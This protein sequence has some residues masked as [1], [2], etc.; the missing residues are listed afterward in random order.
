MS[1]DQAAGAGGR[2]GT[3]PAPRTP[4][5][6]ELRSDNAGGPDSGPGAVQDTVQAR[7]QWGRGVVQAV[8]PL[9]TFSRVK[10]RRE[11]S[12]ATTWTTWTT[13]TGEHHDEQAPRPAVSLERPHRACTRAAIVE[14]RH[15]GPVLAH[16]RGARAG[17]T[18]RRRPHRSGRWA[19]AVEPGTRDRAEQQ[20]RGRSTWCRDHE[21]AARC[22]TV[23][24]WTAGY[25]P[26]RSRARAVVTEPVFFRAHRYPRLRLQ[27]QILPLKSR[28]S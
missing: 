16:R 7:S 20:V 6:K 18:L 28:T 8:H 15:R 21:R 19:R 22:S 2:A 25:S 23:E 24:Q 4:R 12:R 17:L 11:R 10:K 3:A 5:I 26:W 13:Q 1:V 27:E 9:S 14:A